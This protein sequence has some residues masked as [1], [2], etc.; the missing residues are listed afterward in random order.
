[1]ISRDMGVSTFQIRRH[2]LIVR[3]KDVAELDDLSRVK[4]AGFQGE[5]TMSST[6]V[7]Y[8]RRIF[9]K[10]EAVE[11]CMSASKLAVYHCLIAWSYERV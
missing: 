5:I 6:F 1:M 3:E 8:T 7:R 2:G 9:P 4:R 10:G 11:E